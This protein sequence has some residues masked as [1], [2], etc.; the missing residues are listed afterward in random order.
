M[1]RAYRHTNDVLRVAISPDERT[2]LLGGWDGV[3]VLWPIHAPLLDDV[4]RIV[5]SVQTEVGMTLDETGGLQVLDALS[6]HNLRA[7]LQ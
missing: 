1:G 3:A 6:W 7:K 2:A 5:L 4:E